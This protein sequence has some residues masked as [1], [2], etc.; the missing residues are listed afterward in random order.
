MAGLC[1]FRTWFLA[2][3]LWTAAMAWACYATWP[4]VPLD[5]SPIDPATV[6]AMRW[7]LLRHA[8]FFGALA[9][10]PPLLALLA[11]RSLCSRS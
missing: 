5:I 10:V 9:A 11:G 7:A 6:E 3:L 4:A 2:S 8:L 1:S